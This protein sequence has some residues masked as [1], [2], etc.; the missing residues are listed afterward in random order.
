MDDPKIR[1]ELDGAP[2]F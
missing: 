2:K 1:R